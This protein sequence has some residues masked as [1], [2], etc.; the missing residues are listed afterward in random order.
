MADCNDVNYTNVNEL[1]VTSEIVNGDK[2][3]VQKNGNIAT[4]LDFEDLIIGLEN[5]D[6]ADVVTTN[7]TFVTNFKS[8]IAPSIANVRISPV[9]NDPTPISGEN[10]SN[11]LYVHPYRGN[12]ITLYNTSTQEWEQKTL[13]SVI[14]YP[15][16]G[17]AANTN[18]DVW[19]YWGGANL[20]VELSQ[21]SSSLAG[22]GAPTREYRDGVT[23]QVGSHNKRLIGCIRTTTAGNTIQS[24]GRVIAGGA[25]TRQ[26][27]WNAQNRVPVSCWSFETGRWEFD[28][29]SSWTGYANLNRNGPN[30]GRD[31]RLS[32]II[33]DDTQI[34]MTG[35]TYPNNYDGQYIVTYCSIAINQENTPIF[36]QGSMLV[37]ELPGGNSTPRSQLLRSFQSGY[38]FCQVVENIM[39]GGGR[40][41]VNEEHQ[42]QCGFIATFEM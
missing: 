18:Y 20:I 27:V 36:G 13:N 25:N 6:F 14:A 15:L 31:N 4:R 28:G 24:F 21:W 34:N 29:S 33:G 30:N 5:V 40:V 10:E 3:L 39:T 35:Q 22:A 32:F 38:H 11:T 12:T 19:L 37:S 17:T 42:N 16:A 1:P 26:Y 23:V 2:F 41:V 9:F 7:N 8:S